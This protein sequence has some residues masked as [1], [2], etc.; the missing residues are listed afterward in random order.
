M[1]RTSLIV[2]LEGFMETLPVAARQELIHQILIHLPDNALVKVYQESIG[3][4][5]E[6]F[7]EEVPS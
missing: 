5:C 2:E 4:L 7:G 3:D 6:E 1:N